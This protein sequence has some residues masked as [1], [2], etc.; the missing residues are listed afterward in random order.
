MLLAIFGSSTLQA[1]KCPR[2]FYDCRGG[3]GWYVDADRDGYC[4]Y[5][6]FTDALWKKLT[7][8]KDSISNAILAEQ[9][10]VADS[11]A[12]ANK[13][14]ELKNNTQ[15]K[16]EKVDT[17]AHKNCPLENTP[18]C[19]KNSNAQIK[20]TEP[21]T[22]AAL[23]NPNPGFQPPKYDL[24]SVFFACIVFYIFTLFLSKIRVFKKTTHRKIWNTL[25]L[26]TF[27]VTGIFGLLLVI[28]LNYQVLFSWFKTLI[29][30]HVEFGIAMAAISILH[31]IWHWKYFYHIFKKAKK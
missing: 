12:Q 27:L 14:K 1:Q 18:Q 11:M 24:I 2:N 23:P 13:A 4:D 8:H 19:E 16:K 10:R 31:I 6:F 25:L 7:H 26:I 20:P 17:G 21:A 28:Q 5:T 9:Q 29:Y 30:W 15:A 22:T 3:C